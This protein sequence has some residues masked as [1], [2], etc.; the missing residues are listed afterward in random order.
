VTTTHKR[1]R[2]EGGLAEG[3]YDNYGVVVK[4]RSEFGGYIRTEY[5]R[6]PL[7]HLAAIARHNQQHHNE[8]GRT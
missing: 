1:Y 4:L 3:H 2:L 5:V 8:R 7:R 6:V